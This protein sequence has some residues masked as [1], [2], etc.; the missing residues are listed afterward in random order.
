MKQTDY[1][2]VVPSPRLWISPQYWRL[3]RPGSHN[4][5]IMIVFTSQYHNITCTVPYI[6]PWSRAHARKQRKLFDVSFS[7][8]H[9]R[10]EK[11]TLILFILGPGTWA[12]QLGTKAAVT[13]AA[14]DNLTADNVTNLT[15]SPLLHTAR[16]SVQTF[17]CQNLISSMTIEYWT[18]ARGK[19]RNN[20]TNRLKS[21]ILSR[22]H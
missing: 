8:L 18:K 13:R 2:G 4:K 15:F 7:F 3:Y 21:D 11:K 19:C 12:G 9:F 1:E 14:N 22:K 10:T 16:T 20:D 5:V 17:H 6:M